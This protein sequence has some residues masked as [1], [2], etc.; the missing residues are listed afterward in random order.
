MASKLKALLQ[1]TGLVVGVPTSLPHGL[2]WSGTAEKP[3]I[4]EILD[5]AAIYTVT[6][7]TVNVTV[8]RLAG[9]PAACNIVVESW[10]TIERAFDGVQ[11]TRLSASLLVIQGG[12]G[13]TTGPTGS[14][15]ATGPASGPTGSAGST[16]PTGSTGATGPTGATGAASSVTGPTGAASTVTG[17]TGPAGATG[18]TGPAAGAPQ[19]FI[20]SQTGGD[21]DTIVINAGRGLLARGSTNYLVQATMGK[22]SLGVGVVG[23]DPAAFMTTQFTLKLT[24]AWA[25]GDSI[26]FTVEDLT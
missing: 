3:D 11:N 12:T 9:A 2:N 6:A 7:D 17:P 22:N 14:T 26:M 25:A 4:A 10:H 13:G 23:C 5:G 15:G 18:F 16:G 21:D 1:F 24:S 8:T 20:V 19:R